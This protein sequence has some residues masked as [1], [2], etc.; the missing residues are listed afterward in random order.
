M[1]DFTG[2]NEVLGVPYRISTWI[3]D[4]KGTL[5]RSY[6]NELTLRLR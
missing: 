1:R 3:T 6:A 4:H 2:W 5:G